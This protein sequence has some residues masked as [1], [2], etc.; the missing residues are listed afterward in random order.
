MRYLLLLLL[1]TQYNLG[2]SQFCIGDSE[3]FTKSVLEQKKIKYTVDKITDTSNRI[4]YIIEN[5]YQMIFL[6]NASGIINSQTLIPEKKNGVNEFVRWFNRDFVVISDTE[7]RNYSKGR[8]FK[9][10]LE[11]I[12]HEPYFKIT[13]SSSS[14]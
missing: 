2:Y 10:Q 4:S 11:H 9:I 8:I 1:F 12:L 6:F 7:W 14:Q 3:E 5:E 13:L